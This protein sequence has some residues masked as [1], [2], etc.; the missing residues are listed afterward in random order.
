MSI[1]AV[2][3][4]LDDTLFPEREYVESC[5]AAVGEKLKEL[6][7]IEDGKAELLALMEK[8][9][10]D[11]IGR[12]LK[13]H[14]ITDEGALQ[15]LV[16]VY[17]EHV[18]ELTLSPETKDTLVKLREAGFKLG[19]ITDGRPNGQRAKISALGLEDLV[20][21]II[22]TDELG[23]EEFRKPNPAAFEMMARDLD[24]ALDE[25]MYVGDNPQKDFA[26]GEKGVK[27][28]RYF[29]N[30][31]YAGKDYVEHIEPNHVVC[32]IQEIIGIVYGEL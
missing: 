7:D 20:D 11:T 27:T 19:I 18:P 22:I 12:L 25:M 14:G 3:F 13:A 30:G 23:G 16:C 9:R 17:R 21:K 8:S 15:R 28:V 29:N 5:F 32:G 24:V 2:V 1:K 31:I 26:I 10:S 4:D 6:Y